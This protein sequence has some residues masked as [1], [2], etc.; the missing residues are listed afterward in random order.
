MPIYHLPKE[1]IF[2][3]P[4]E[5]EPEGILAIG[6]GLEPER[7]VL[8]YRMGIFPWYDQNTPILWWS[9]DPRLLLYPSEVHVSKSLK[10]V[11]RS[12]KFRVTLDQAFSQVIEACAETRRNGQEGTWILEEIKTAYS[13]LHRRGY[14]HSVEV[15]H[16]EVL[17]GGLYGVSLGAAFFGESMFSHQPDASKTALVYLSRQLDHWGFDLIDCQV[18][19]DHLKRLGAIEVPRG[20]FLEQLGQALRF[21]T[22][23]GTWAFD[24][25]EDRLRLG[26]GEVK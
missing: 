5:A 9:P 24:L 18:P 10:R 21:E 16:D 26:L 8:A 11:L 15:W 20:Q 2:P 23:L 6:G 13:E 19:T 22:R 1:L 25:D 17:V 14:A 3:H 7:L 4:E 12:G